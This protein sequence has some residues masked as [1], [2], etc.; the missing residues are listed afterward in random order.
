MHKIRLANL[1][2]IHTLQVFSQTPCERGGAAGRRALFGGASARSV[3]EGVAASWRRRGDG[4]AAKTRCRG[5]AEA[6]A[7]S[8][9]AA[10][11]STPRRSPR[12]HRSGG[13]LRSGGSAGSPEKNGG[14]RCGRR[15][16]RR[17][18]SDLAV[19]EIRA[20]PA[21]PRVL[22]DTLEV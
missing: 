17:E 12:V 5:T 3:G 20:L 19:G 13:A 2:R 21:F 1:H 9:T 15:R 11:K 6:S 8:V 4:E 10:P 16:E 18:L 14:K 7:A 22:D